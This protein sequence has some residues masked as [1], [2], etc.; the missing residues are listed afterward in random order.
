MRYAHA[1]DPEYS[2]R[3]SSIRQL[4]RRRPFVASTYRGTP[5]PQGHK[6]AYGAFWGYSEAI[7]NGKPFQM[8]GYFEWKV[9]KGP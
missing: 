1:A 9:L 3:A 8:D 2:L 7:P 4:I 6:L 5:H